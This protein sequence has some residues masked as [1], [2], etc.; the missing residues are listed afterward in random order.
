MLNL[1]N[2]AN[3]FRITL[4]SQKNALKQSRTS[5]V[6]LTVT[7]SDAEK[8]ILVSKNQVIQTKVDHLLEAPKERI[9][10]R[11]KSLILYTRKVLKFFGYALAALLVAVAVLSYT[12]EMK[13]RIVLTGSMSPAIKS[14]DIIITIPPT[15][16]TP[17]KGDVVAYLGKRFDGSQVGVFSHRIIGGDDQTGFIVKGDA[18]PSP[19]VQRPKISDITGVVIYVIPFLGRLLSPRTLLVL[20]PII[21]GFWLVFEALRDE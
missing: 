19:D 15:K 5:N 4:V 11:P 1:V 7:G 20:T 9:L 8:T 14:G 13:A 21:I 10:A 17:V 18:N 2:G 12:G 6:L 16:K 3:G